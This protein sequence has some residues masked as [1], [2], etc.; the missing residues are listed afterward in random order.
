MIRRVAHCATREVL[1][2]RERVVPAGLSSTS[3]QEFLSAILA[4]ASGE[5][6]AAIPIPESYRA[7]FVRR[8][9]QAMF[10]GL[11]S[12]DKDPRKSLHVGEVATPE[13]APDEAYIAVMASA[14][15]FNTVWT[16][17]FEPLPT[18]GFLDRLGREGV[19]GARHALDDHVV[20]SDASAV[21]LQVG[22]A[23]RMLEA[24]RQGHRPLQLRRRPE[25]DR[26]R[27]LDAGRQPAHL[28][29]RDQLRRPGRPGRGQGQPADAQAGPPVV[30]GGGRQRPVQL[31]LLPDAGVAQRGP[32]HPGRQGA[33]VGRLGRPR[34]LRRAVLPQRRG[35]AGGRGV[36]ASPRSTC[37]TTWASR[38]S[39][40]AR[41]PTTGSGR[42]STPRTS[43]SGAAWARTSAAWS[44]T[45]STS[46]SSTPVARP[47][48]PRCSRPSG[49]AP[50]SPVRRPRAT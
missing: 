42:T 10:E 7:A 40:T 36:L 14:I 46:C 6:L 31:D 37:S 3:M 8:D 16:S 34:R 48:A 23:V 20:G 12:E 15:N 24:G 26:P 17:I 41:R 11:E 39:S 18:F 13:L 33:G 44:A 35:H 27:R 38:R 9:E 28:G 21:V 19:W 25:P 45:T 4:G 29:L 5:E 49:A 50:S 2:P 47:W 43:R 30:G 32:D 22:S 1:R